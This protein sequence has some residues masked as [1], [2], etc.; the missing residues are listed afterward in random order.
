M[1]YFHDTNE[2]NAYYEALEEQELYDSA[3]KI[4]N[5][6]IKK[7]AEEKAT[8]EKEATEALEKERKQ[9]EKLE[10]EAK[11]PER[12]YV[13]D[14]ISK[15]MNEYELLH[16]SLEKN[17]I[18]HPAIFEA[19]SSILLSF[20]LYD[21][22]D[23]IF[24]TYHI[25]CKLDFF[26]D[27]NYVLITLN[28]E[29]MK[30]DI[31]MKLLGYEEPEKN[32]SFIRSEKDLSKKYH[33]V[34]Q[35]INRLLTKTSYLLCIKEFIRNNDVK[36]RLIF[37]FWNNATC[38]QDEEALFDDN[39]IM[40]PDYIPQEYYCGRYIGFINFHQEWIDPILYNEKNASDPK[41]IDEPSRDAIA[42]TCEEFPDIFIEYEYE[43]S[44]YEEY[45][46]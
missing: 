21:F 17:Q 25:K 10:L 15:I 4:V 12:N 11:Y 1:S 39:E 26:H 16:I 28:Q 24:C 33:N 29:F 2:E 31:L 36:K 20:Q 8:A 14:E 43:D 13:Y 9:R 37:H 30:S 40:K 23:D 46:D 35:E 34:I 38:I 18:V 19:H 27:F 41:N 3:W 6:K 32:I 22:S 5:Y 44:D 42:K 45:D 7:E